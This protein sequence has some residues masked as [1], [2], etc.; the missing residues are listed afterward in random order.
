[1]ALEDKTVCQRADRTWQ[2]RCWQGEA[3]EGRILLIRAEQGFGDTLQFCRYA[4]LAAARGLRVVLEVQPALVKLMGSVKGV[5]R[6]IAQGQPLPDFDLYCPM[7]SLPAAFNT[8]LETIPADVPYLSVDDESVKTWR[9]RLSDGNSKRLKV[10]LVWAGKPRFNSPDLIAADRRRSIVPDL[11][12]PLMDIA[13]IQF[14]SLQ[15]D[16]PPAP[17]GIR[18]DR[19]DG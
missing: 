11:L 18:P 3:A 12:A 16:G 9:N 13:G 7:M 19:P 5:E 10:G 8:R 14:Y 2:S 15:K 17:E 6:V 4:P 1:M